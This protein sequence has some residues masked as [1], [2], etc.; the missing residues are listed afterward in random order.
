MADVSGE[1]LASLLESVVGAVG[2]DLEDVAV[3]RAGKRTS[4]VVVVDRD[5][6]VDLDAVAEATRA[7]STELDELDLFGDSPY[8][9][10][11]TSPGI[12][13]PLTLPKHWRRAVTRKV[14]VSMTDGSEIVGRIVAADETT[15]TVNDGKLDHVIAF[16]D[17]TKAL[18]QIDFNPIPQD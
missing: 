6:G 17:V 8:L 7:V 2:L 9:L 1:R 18:V 15:A 11:V 12:D 10:E 5:G 16:A 4:V 14:A 3:R 13:R